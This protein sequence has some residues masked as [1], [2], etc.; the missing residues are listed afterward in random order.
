MGMRRSG[1]RRQ[2]PHAHAPAA[3]HGQPRRRHAK[4]R[5]RVLCADDAHTDDILCSGA[6]DPGNRLRAGNS[7][8]S[9]DSV[10]I[11]DRHA[12]PHSTGQSHCCTMHQPQLYGTSCVLE[13]IRT[14]QSWSRWQGFCT[15]AIDSPI[16]RCNAPFNF[17]PAPAFSFPR[18][19]AHV[20]ANEASMGLSGV[21]LPANGRTI[22]LMTVAPIV[23]AP[24]RTSYAAPSGAAQATPTART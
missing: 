12:Y 24:T 9:P 21:G 5:A 16:E 8:R 6:A 19:I 15:A 1:V 20:A 7:V 14:T 4:H 13:D 10:A 17:P 22:L 3:R 18:P 11:T 23:A 2:R